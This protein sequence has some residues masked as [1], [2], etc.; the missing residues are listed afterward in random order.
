MNVQVNWKGI[1]ITSS[2]I[3]YTREQDICTGFNTLDM[4]VEAKTARAFAPWDTITVYENGDKMAEYNVSSAEQSVPDGTYIVSCQDDSK[5]L[6]DYFIDKP[7]EVTYPSTTRYWIEK[8]LAEAGVSYNINTASYGVPVSENTSL[9][10]QALYD[11]F[12]QLLQ[13]SAWYFYFDENSVCQ[14]GRLTSDPS[15]TES[16]TGS[17][18]TNIGYVKNDKLLRNRVIVW[19]AG[20]TE[21]GQWIFADTSK[22]TPWNRPDGDYRTIVYSNP[23]IKTFGIAYYLAL[24]ILNE[25]SQTIPEKSLTVD[26][27]YSTVTPGCKVQGSTTYMTAKGKVTH[28]TVNVGS[29]GFTSTYTLDQRCPR[30]FGYVDYNDF[31][32]IGTR[33][34]G[35][36]RKQLLSPTWVD[37]S[38]GITDLDIKDVSAYNGLLGCVA[39][40]E[41]KLYIR[42]TSLAAWMPYEPDGLLNVSVTSGEPIL[43]TSG[44]IAEAC[45]INRN[46]SITGSVTVAYTI[47]AS[48]GIPSGSSMLFPP[49]GNLSWVQAVDLN[50]IP[51]YSQQIVVTSGSSKSYD[52]AVVDMDTNWDG[53]NLISVYNGREIKTTTFV[54]SGE[55]CDFGGDTSLGSDWKGSSSSIK[56][57]LPSPTSGIFVEASTGSYPIPNV[58]TV[59]NTTITHDA[60]VYIDDDYETDGEVSGIHTYSIASSNSTLTKVLFNAASGTATHYDYNIVPALWTDNLTWIKNFYKV[61]STH[62]SVV[63]LE[64]DTGSKLLKFQTKFIEISDITGS[65]IVTSTVSINKSFETTAQSNSI[66]GITTVNY[67]DHYGGKYYAVGYRVVDGSENV[68]TISVVNMLDGSITDTEICRLPEPFNQAI[69]PQIFLSNAQT[70]IS[71]NYM[72][73]G[74]VWFPPDSAGWTWHCYPIL[75][76]KN[77]GNV[78]SVDVEITPSTFE[79]YDYTTYLGGSTQFTEGNHPTKRKDFFYTPCNE[80]PDTGVGWGKFFAFINTKGVIG[81]D[82]YKLINHVDIKVS[83]DMTYQEN[84]Y[85]DTYT[86]PGDVFV[87]RES[88]L[89]MFEVDYGSL[90]E[91]HYNAQFMP[92]FSRYVTNTPVFS[93]FYRTDWDDA[94]LFEWAVFLDP[95]DFE[96]STV[97][98][99]PSAPLDTYGMTRVEFANGMMDDIDD[100]IYLSLVDSAHSDKMIAGYNTDGSIKKYM[101]TELAGGGY[102][103]LNYVGQVLQN[104]IYRPGT[105]STVVYYYYPL[106]S[107]I[108]ET[109]MN[110]YLILLHNP[111]T[112]SGQF[113]II[114]T[115]AVPLMVDTSKNL[116]TVFYDIPQ[117]GGIEINSLYL[118]SSFL[119]ELD[120]FTEIYPAAPV[121]DA[122]TFDVSDAFGTFPVSGADMGFLGR[123][124]GVAGGNKGLLM[125]NSELQTDEYQTIFSGGCF[126]H[127]DFTNNDPDPYMFVCASGVSASGVS[128]SGRFYQRNTGEFIWND[129]SSTLP[130]SEISI[131]RADD[132]M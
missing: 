97:I 26:G 6:T 32:Y 103:D 83:T 128:A 35:V 47:L 102:Y 82:G 46:Y 129:Y 25:F 75:V 109:P 107:G 68:Y 23:A 29:D 123:F 19:G 91:R 58:Y 89:W 105:D 95:S 54:V 13:M 98:S 52:V 55:K 112:P 27:S 45:S 77:N 116:P 106:G 60:T 101:F 79:N 130:A 113:D 15:P 43:L 31:V 111:T 62:Y 59:Y 41:G 104:K 69:E 48:G 36:W 56:V 90:T 72:H 86:Y 63:H 76:N 99:Y 53:N 9:G 17:Q 85:T 20:D 37:Y 33:G 92:T 42:H 64:A 78:S 124:I 65:G 57:F 5:R 7:Y 44:I 2:V 122:R 28:I 131:I 74:M 39:L 118:G 125:Y 21:T 94:T 16:F 24:L 100:S 38:T 34:S 84:N 18:I 71:P 96:T 70:G 11:V 119:N 88:K 66:G 67:V 10:M 8:L 121:H 3:Q 81:T 126:T 87:S 115:S 114:H 51:I 12:L 110:K 30:M 127:L 22:L 1:D 73:F 50:R 93:Q 14:I 4:T 117:S 61:D 108:R 40:N 80:N 49:S 132:R 120:S